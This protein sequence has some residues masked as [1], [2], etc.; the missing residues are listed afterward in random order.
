MCVIVIGDK[1]VLAPIHPVVT[2]RKNFMANK[3][4]RQESITL[5]QDAKQVWCKVLPRCELKDR[6]VVIERTS[7]DHSRKHIVASPDRVRAWLRF[8]FKNHKGFIRMQQDGELEMSEDAFRILETEDDLAEVLNDIED[9]VDDDDDD[10]NENDNEADNKDAG[11]NQPE[12]T[13]GFS[14]TDVYT[15]DKFPALY[16]KSKEFLKI[17]QVPILQFNLI[18]LLFIISLLTLVL[19]T[20]F[21]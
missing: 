15:F 2:V 17:K 3:K 6:F 10:N 16:L 18:T 4:L 8:L 20:L 5:M 1:A 7:K 12:M 13:S 21:I 14:S 11:V 9:D 19:C